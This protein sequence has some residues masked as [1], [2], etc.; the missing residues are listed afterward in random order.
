MGLLRLNKLKLFSLEKKSFGASFKSRKGYM[1]AK[2]VS[3][4][5]HR[6][7]RRGTRETQTHVS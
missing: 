2:L 1:A 6:G 7:E 3:F 4:Y 5:L